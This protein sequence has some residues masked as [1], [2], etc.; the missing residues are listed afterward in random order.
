MGE[1]ERKKGMHAKYSCVHVE[2]YKFNACMRC[3][4]CNHHL[5]ISLDALVRVCLQ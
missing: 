2:S 4:V 1:S 5:Y 3:D